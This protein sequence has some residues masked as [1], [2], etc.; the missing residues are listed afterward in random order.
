MSKEA[1]RTSHLTGEE[2][3]REAERLSRMEKSLYG[4]HDDFPEANAVALVQ[5][6]A[7]L[8]VAAHLAR[9]AGALESQ[10]ERG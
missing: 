10:Q 5:V 7:T 3:F 1:G 6:H 4:G 2:H 9:I 8:A